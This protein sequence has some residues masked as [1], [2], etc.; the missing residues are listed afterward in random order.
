MLSVVLVN[1]C[2]SFCL[3]FRDLSSHGDIHNVILECFSS[4]NEEVKSA[5]SYALGRYLIS[6]IYEFFNCTL[7]Q[8][9]SAKTDLNC[10]MCN[11][12]ASECFII[13]NRLFVP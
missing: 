6:G 7:I 4:P 11:A 1:F 2:C 8:N 10:A 12:F 9:G 13:S 5:A 3:P